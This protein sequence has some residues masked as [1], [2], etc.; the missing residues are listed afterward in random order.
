MCRVTG[1]VHQLLGVPGWVVLL[2]AGAL[3]LAEDA[4]FV[5][6]VIP[7]ETAAILGG[8]SA[9]LGHVSLTA[10]MVTV[11]LAAVVGDTI[12]YE[13]GKH[14]GG[15]ALRS[16]LIDRHRDRLEGAQALLA[17]RG[18]PAV[19]LGRWI[20]FFRAMMPALAGMSRMRYRTFF[21]YNAAG[22]LVWGVAVVVVGYLAGASYARVERYL[23]PTTAAAVALVV[24]AAVVVWLL[25]RRTRERDGA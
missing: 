14:L 8:A 22:G 9:R 3:V 20:A 17:R 18:G 2:V 11:V 10:V 16:P 15:R 5:G 4:V 19:F 24:L 13:V 7:G 6:F 12:G 21:V 1:L 25:R 23:G